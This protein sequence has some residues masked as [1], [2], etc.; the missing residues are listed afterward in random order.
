MVEQ[1][2]LYKTENGSIGRHFDHHELRRILDTAAEWRKRHG[3]TLTETQQLA[4]DTVD[5]MRIYSTLDGDLSGRLWTCF[6]L[7]PKY[8]TLVG[9]GVAVDAENNTYLDDHEDNLFLIV[10]S[11]PL[12]ECVSTFDVKLASSPCSPFLAPCA[13]PTPLVAQPKEVID[14]L[15]E[16]VRGIL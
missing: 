2:R 7:F 1:M 14:E 13:F 6:T 5:S 12:A 4:L 10:Y 9:R 15:F 11:R 16:Q 3:V 8:E